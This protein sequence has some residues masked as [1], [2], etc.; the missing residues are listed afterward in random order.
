MTLVES[1]ETAAGVADPVAGVEIVVRR[2]DRGLT[3][4]VSGEIDIATVDRFEDAIRHA[5]TTGAPRVVIDLTGVT[6][7]S[8]CGI[9]V[10]YEH[11]SRVVAVLVTAGSVVDRALGI[12]GYPAI[13]LP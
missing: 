11:R 6:F 5:T 2:H 4:V 10:L 1:F 9:R 12:A 7:V 8:C 13:V 3:V